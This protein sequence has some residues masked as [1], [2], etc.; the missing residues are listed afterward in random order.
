M[1]QLVSRILLAIFLFPLAAMFYLVM[2]FI[3]EET[4]RL[5]GNVYYRDREA[6]GF[7]FCGVIT[8][9]GVA[10]YWWLLWRASVN[11]NS[12]RTGRTVAAV[13]V[14]A[15][16]GAAIGGLLF[17]ASPGRDYSFCMFVTT[18]LAILLWLVATVF[19]WRETAAERSA[20]LAGAGNAI[21][22]P[23]CGYNLTGLHESRCPECGTKFTLDEL[24]V[25][26][27]AGAA[28]IA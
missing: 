11:W 25:A 5:G 4:L 24:L 16:C 6:V 9:I 19:I 28:D 21:T 18:V 26:Q 14:C 7:L 1:S 3:F 17:L 20:R 10:I 22:C 27:R 2:F 13:V 8:W 23:T 15:V 12:Q